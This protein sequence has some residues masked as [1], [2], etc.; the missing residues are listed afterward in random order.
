MF[1]PLE[2]S[3]GVF[4]DVYVRHIVSFMSFIKQDVKLRENNFKVSKP[5]AITAAQ[6]EG[7]GGAGD[8]GT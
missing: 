7:G 8:G 1:R 6:K 4:S 5:D 2:G 3:D